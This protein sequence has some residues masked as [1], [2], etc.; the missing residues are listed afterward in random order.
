MESFGKNPN[1]GSSLC[2]EV[3]KGLAFLLDNCMYKQDLLETVFCTDRPASYNLE[4]DKK[5]S[6]LEIYGRIPNITENGNPLVK[7]LVGYINRNFL[8]KND[9]LTPIHLGAEV[10]NEESIWGTID[11]EELKWLRDN[12]IV[13]NDFEG[14][15]SKHNRRIGF[16][17][18]TYW[19]WKNY[20]KLGNPEYFGFFGYRKLF[21][22][23]FLENLHKYDMILPAP[24]KMPWGNDVKE[25]Y[26]KMHNYKVFDKAMDILNRLYPEEKAL[27]EEYFTS[28]CG[29]YHEIYIL[30][31]DLFFE[32]CEWMFPVLFE[33]LAIDELEFKLTSQEK[34]R[35]IKI[36]KQH[37][38]S[39]YS[40]EESFDKYQKRDLAYMIERITGYY[41]FK[42]TQ[43][44]ETLKYLEMPIILIDN[45]RGEDFLNKLRKNVKKDLSIKE[46]ACK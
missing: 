34:Q 16:L 6:L 42:L 23:S 3:I 43:T 45:L 30:K 37:H 32:F 46:M 40:D 13:D 17:T 24:Y 14:N 36:R 9:I 25:Q 27:I 31:K 28:T 39:C 1:I 22:P 4:D 35:L 2:K 20:E 19:A 7:I 11:E 12:C 5:S 44:R 38:L 10:A 26:L 8:F 15:I 21:E 18:G 29:Y 41:L 33:V